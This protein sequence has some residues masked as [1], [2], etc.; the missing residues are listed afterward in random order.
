LYT[1][2]DRS[3]P[4]FTSAGRPLPA[5]SE[6]A[7]NPEE[8]KKVR[9]AVEDLTAVVAAKR[10]ELQKAE[11][12]LQEAQARLSK[13]EGK[14]ATFHL[15]FASPERGLRFEMGNLTIPVQ[16]NPKEKEK[17]KWHGVI[18]LDNLKLDNLILTP[19]KA[20]RPAAQDLNQRLERLLREV[21]Q[22]RREIQRPAAK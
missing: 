12:R 9:S 15:R 19:E 20:V 7:A 5:T 8:V 11:K 2:S 1:T 4:A 16:P 22:L 10:A 14:S 3:T 13:L 18:R 17:A 21:E 6:P